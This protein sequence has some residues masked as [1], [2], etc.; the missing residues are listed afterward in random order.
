[1]G[2]RFHIPQ[3]A[4]LEG[5]HGT[6]CGAGQ[7]P[8]GYAAGRQ[9]QRPPMGRGVP[10][11][12]SCPAM[13]WHRAGAY[14]PQ[15][16]QG[17]GGPE[18]PRCQAGAGIGVHAW[19]HMAPQGDGCAGPRPPGTCGGACG[20]TGPSLPGGVVR[21]SVTSAGPRVRGQWVQ[22]CAHGGRSESWR[23]APAWRCVL[24]ARP[25]WWRGAPS[26]P[27]VGVCLPVGTQCAQWGRK[28]P[29]RYAGGKYSAR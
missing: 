20:R 23:Q 8:G 7:T 21:S 4:W 10:T 13:G 15:S 27:S 6:A 25:V 18:C 26:P 14:P 24:R 28:S 16:R 11:A 19:R 9:G 1:M 29:V 12:S 2:G 17:P 22:W 5:K 3:A